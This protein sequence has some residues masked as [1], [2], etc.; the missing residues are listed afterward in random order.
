MSDASPSG[1]ALFRPPYDRFEI[2]QV[3]E[4]P[5]QNGPGTSL[6]WRY[7]GNGKQEHEAEL[8]RSRPPTVPLV[9]L[10]PPAD[11]CPD[12]TRTLSKV[13]RLKPKAILTDHGDPSVYRIQKALRRRPANLPAS[14]CERI[15]RVCKK[16]DVEVLREVQRLFEVAREVTSVNAAVSR[17]YLSRRT[18]GRHFESVGLP[19]PSHVLQFARLI[20][21]VVDMQATQTSIRI[22][23]RLLKYPDSYTLSN[24]MLRMVGVRPS[25]AKTCLGWEWVLESWLEREGLFDRES[26]WNW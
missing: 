15:R 17:L 18:L 5:V 19:C 22:A 12:L 26:A 3:H 14:C 25:V 4:R 2:L 13:R 8:L 24:Q 1:L 21:A 10:V 6:V 11:T 9:V 23:S 7:G 16:E 20:T